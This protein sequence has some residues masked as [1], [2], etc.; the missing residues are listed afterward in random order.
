MTVKYGIFLAN[1][2]N[3]GYG[4]NAAIG[5]TMLHIGDFD[6]PE[7]AADYIRENPITPQHLIMQYWIVQ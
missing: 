1:G 7:E 3:H 4:T 5:I 6:S 2:T